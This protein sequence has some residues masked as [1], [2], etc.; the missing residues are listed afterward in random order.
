MQRDLRKGEIERETLRIKTNK[1]TTKIQQSCQC[2]RNKQ[3]R[4]ANRGNET[5]NDDHGNNNQ[6][7]DSD[8][9]FL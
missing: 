8:K 6:R 2:G 3:N 4:K 9:N 1:L 7:N 5:S